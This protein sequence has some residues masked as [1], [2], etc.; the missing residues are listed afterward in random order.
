MYLLQRGDSNTGA[1]AESGWKLATGSGP[2]SGATSHERIHN[3]KA[4]E[5]TAVLHIL[6]VENSAT[7][8]ESGANDQ[9][10]PEIELVKLV[11]T[12]YT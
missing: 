7:A 10:I 5:S 1:R 8:R 4:V 12:S 3:L 2:M 9:A 11:K 6:R